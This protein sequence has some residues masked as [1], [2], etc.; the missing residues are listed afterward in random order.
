M[1]QGENS[2]ETWKNLSA[3][4]GGANTPQKT[5]ISPQI[6]HQKTMFC[7]LFFAKTPEK[8]TLHQR[9]F[10]L[11]N[12]Y[13][14]FQDCFYPCLRPLL[15]KRATAPPSGMMTGKTISQSHNKPRCSTW[16]IVTA[17]D[18]GVPHSTGVNFRFLTVIYR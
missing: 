10:L 14:P 1:G 13:A 15:R 9:N 17:R 8:T 6:H 2:F 11:G 7:A 12:I 4:I 5:T 16:N 18:T 3:E